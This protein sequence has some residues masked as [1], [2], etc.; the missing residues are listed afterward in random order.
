MRSIL[1]FYAIAVV[2]MMKDLMAKTAFNEI[3][4]EGT[5]TTVMAVLPSVCHP[6]YG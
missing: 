3:P 4:I 1:V 6:E 5:G 2:E